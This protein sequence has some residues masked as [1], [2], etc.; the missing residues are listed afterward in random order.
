MTSR[1][2]EFMKTEAFKDYY[3]IEV[4]QYITDESQRSRVIKEIDNCKTAEEA[5]AIIMKA[6]G[7]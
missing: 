7:E 1:W 4:F 5:K 6:R 2:D 3:C